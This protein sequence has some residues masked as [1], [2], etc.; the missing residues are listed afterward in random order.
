MRR[1]ISV[2]SQKGGVG[3]TTTVLNLGFTMSR[4]G[5]RVLLVDGDPQGGIAIAVDLKKRTSK[6]M[7]DVLRGRC[8]PAEII[9]TTK[10][11]TLAVAGIGALEPE[12]IPFLEAEAAS[13]RLRALLGTLGSDF[14]TVFLDA[15][16]G[17]GS[18]VTALLGASDGVL[19]ISQCKTLSLKS[20]PAFLKLVQWVRQR[21]NP[22]LEFEGIVFSMVENSP[23]EL[24]LHEMAQQMFPDDAVFKTTVP[25]DRAFEQASARAVP[26]A[27]LRGETTLRRVYLDLAMELKE[28]LLRRDLGS[29]QDDER[30]GLF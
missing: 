9:M 25:Y 15:P 23:Y 18:L 13:G 11:N 19:L 16:A 30:E 24:Q 29:D 14:S 1:I 20:L 26:V 4:L 21:G 6:G 17:L 28:R 10:E 5:G 22:S 12:D 8:A 3:K 27:M 7:I 2:A